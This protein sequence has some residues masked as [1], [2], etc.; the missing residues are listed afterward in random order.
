MMP[1]IYYSRR[2]RCH[3]AWR[4]RGCFPALLW[5]PCPAWPR[6]PYRPSM[7]VFRSGAA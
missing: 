1:A 2:L 5:C 4:R 3:A 6:G 7:G